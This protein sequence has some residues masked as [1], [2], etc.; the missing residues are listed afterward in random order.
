MKTLS[1]IAAGLLAFGVSAPAEETLKEKTRE[2][3]EATKD[4]ASKAGEKIQ[5][6]T[7]KMVEEGKE[8]ITDED[9]PKIEVT[10]REH[11]IKMPSTVQSGTVHFVV[12][13]EGKHEHN[14]EIEGQGLEKKF[15]MNVEPG[16]TKTLEVE[17]KAG[18][19]KVYCPVEDHDEKGMTTK[20]VVK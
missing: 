9:A 3:I 6:A 5:S 16:D 20:L 15:M 12:T 4:A 17:L 7:E 14:F 10:L 2:A 8:L 19:Y 11:S 18:T 1:I 13:N